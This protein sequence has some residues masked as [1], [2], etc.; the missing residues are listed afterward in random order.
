MK[1]QLLLLLLII[2]FNFSSWAQPDYSE[3]TFRSKLKEYKK[4]NNVNPNAYATKGFD[5]TFDT[6]LRICQEDG[7]V[8]S[9]KNSISEQVENTFDYSF[10]EGK[11]VNEGIYIMYY[12]TDYTIKQAQ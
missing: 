2:G 9:T 4:K 1:K 5:L 6:I 3:I 12:D 8:P 10:K 7:F 11:N